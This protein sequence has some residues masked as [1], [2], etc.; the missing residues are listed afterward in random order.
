[1]GEAQGEK[2]Q[3]THTTA[4]TSTYKSE[5]IKRPRTCNTCS[6]LKHGLLFVERERERSINEAV[7]LWICNGGGKNHQPNENNNSVE[8][9]N[10][11]QFEIIEY[12]ILYQ[13]LSPP[14]T[15]PWTNTICMFTCDMTVLK[16][17]PYF[18][19]ERK[20]NKPKHGSLD[21]TNSTKTDQTTDR[22]LSRCSN[23]QKFKWMQELRILLC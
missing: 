4:C 13:H 20:S 19:D 7:K 17:Q 18:L 23:T 9:E 12:Y 3:Q 22:L 8:N 15:V 1:M 11:L 10:A 16:V 6:N 5:N 14:K 2:G 21:R